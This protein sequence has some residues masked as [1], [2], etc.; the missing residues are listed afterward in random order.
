M[1]RY[2]L[3]L[4]GTEAGDL[5]SL[6]VFDTDTIII[7]EYS[8]V[9]PPTENKYLN[10]SEKNEDVEEEGIDPPSISLLKEAIKKMDEE[11]D[12]KRLGRLPLQSNFTP[13][14]PILTGTNIPWPTKPTPTTPSGTKVRRQH[15]CSKCGK[16]GHTFKTCMQ[17]E[18]DAPNEEEKEDDDFKVTPQV[19]DDINEMMSD[20]L[21]SREIAT[22]YNISV[23]I[24]NMAIAEAKGI[25]LP[26][27]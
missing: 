11:E 8:E 16:P 18:I 22:H 1:K 24:A 4:K 10:S 26:T 6:L 17:D 5:R 23:K 13:I 2:F 25:T 12:R 7:T 14:G 19:K 9:T 20:G 3:S 27:R 15:H 21:G